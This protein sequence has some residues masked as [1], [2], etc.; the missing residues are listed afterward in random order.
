MPAFVIVDVEITDPVRYEEYR[1]LA[2]PTVAAHG[3]RYVVRGGA[4]RKLEGSWQP[5]RL[6]VLEFPDAERAREWWD[7]D[8]YRPAHHLRE[9]CARTDMI[10]VDGV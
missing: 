10:I 8:D 6:V 1:R 9:T 7:S 2:T 5:G 4:V 3:G